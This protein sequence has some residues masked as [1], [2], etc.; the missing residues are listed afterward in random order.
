MLDSIAIDR[1]DEIF[2]NMSEPQ[3][4]VKLRLKCDKEDE[5]RN[6]TID[7]PNPEEKRSSLL[8][9]TEDIPYSPNIMWLYIKIIDINDN[10][11][12][13]KLYETPIY[14]GYPAGNAVL[15]IY[16]EYLTKI[17]AFDK[18]TGLNAEIK[19]SMRENLYFDIESKTGKIYP[20][21]GNVLKEGEQSELIVLAT[22]QNGEGLMSGTLILVKALT[23]D[24]YSLITVTSNSTK[25]KKELEWELR[26]ET[27]FNIKILKMSYVPQVVQQRSYD[28]QSLS[29]KA[30]IYGYHRH[31]LVTYKELQE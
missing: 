25:S 23:A 2:R 31:Q 20:K 5:L 14:L 28:N 1:E 15:D 17:E 29:C 7:I 19:Y 21:G 22:D 30:W 13:F 3:I 11:P 27:G 16:P 24:H 9:F 10:P 6:L 4:M 26:Q 8:S 12:E 18:D